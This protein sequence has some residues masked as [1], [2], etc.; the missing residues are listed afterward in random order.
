MRRQFQGSKSEEGLL[1]AARG[2]S[3][4]SLMPEESLLEAGE[5]DSKRDDGGEDGGSERFGLGGR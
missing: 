3:E 4:V 1:E 5:G 2:M